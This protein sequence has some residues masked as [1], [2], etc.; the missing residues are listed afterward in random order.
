MNDEMQLWKDV[1]KF[2][3]QYPGLIAIAKKIGEI[4]SLEEWYAGE[5]RKLEALTQEVEKQRKIIA[6]EREAAN[7]EAARKAQELE[8]QVQQHADQLKRDA[9][10]AQATADAV[11]KR[12]SADAS[13]IVGTA[14]AKAKELTYLIEPKKAALEAEIAS[15]LDK[16]TAAKDEH[17]SVTDALAKAKDDHASFLKKLMGTV[18]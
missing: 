6:S 17:A 5:Q 13:T 7:V 12:A 18:G 15:L 10:A 2:L 8:G 9:A 1:Q 11:L 4:G 16:V 3:N 14:Q